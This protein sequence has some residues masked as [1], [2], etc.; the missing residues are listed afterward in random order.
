MENSNSYLTTA[1][2]PISR[3][4]NPSLQERSLELYNV[5]LTFFVGEAD[6]FS[7]VSG[8]RRVSCVETF[9]ALCLFCSL[10]FSLVR[11]EMVCSC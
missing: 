1:Y 11:R 3:H 10:L 6:Y 4:N 7:Y 2:W 5:L 8:P 9:G